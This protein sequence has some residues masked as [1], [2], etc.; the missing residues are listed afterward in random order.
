MRLGVRSIQTARP[1]AEE[2]ADMAILFLPPSF[3]EAGGFDKI[4]PR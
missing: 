3:L 4:V 1:W 2:G